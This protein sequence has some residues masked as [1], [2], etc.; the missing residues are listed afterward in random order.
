M[1]PS[2][3]SPAGGPPPSQDPDAAAPAEAPAGPAPPRGMP[4]A[5]APRRR[6]A[7]DMNRGVEIIREQ[8]R[9]LPDRPGVYRMLN[10]EGDALYVGKARSLKKRVATYTMPAKLP[11]RLQRM[12]SETTSME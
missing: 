8:L 6:R 3:R 4:P 9:L 10:D 2:D 1:N 5:G 11:V 7:A 12:V